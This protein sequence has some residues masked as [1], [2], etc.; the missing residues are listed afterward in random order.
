[1]SGV[2]SANLSTVCLDESLMTFQTGR[3][4]IAT[5]CMIYV[6]KTEWLGLKLQHACGKINLLSIRIKLCWSDYK[7]ML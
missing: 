7:L 6:L 5:C 3:K 4:W 2:K 1:M